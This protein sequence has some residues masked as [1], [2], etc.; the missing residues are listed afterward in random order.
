MPKCRVAEYVYAK[1]LGWDQRVREGG[2]DEQKRMLNSARKQAKEDGEEPDEIQPW[3]QYNELPTYGLS[4][5]QLCRA[6]RPGIQAEPFTHTRTQKLP[7]RLY[8]Q[9][10]SIRSP[11]NAQEALEPGGARQ[12][13]PRGGHVGFARA[14]AM[15]GCTLASE[16]EAVRCLERKQLVRRMSEQGLVVRFDRPVAF[17]NRFPHRLNIGDPNFTSRVL[18]QPSLLKGARVQGDAGSPYPQHLGKKFLGELEAIGVGQIS[19]PEQPAAEP[20]LHVMSSHAGSRLAGLRVNCLF[21]AN[22]RRQ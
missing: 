4:A 19:G 17:T 20:G 5:A 12:V 1:E 15:F 21:M 22:Q 6:S 14:R 10:Q 9:Y 16:G 8:P 18:D 3:W 7:T 2:R 13:G 11:V